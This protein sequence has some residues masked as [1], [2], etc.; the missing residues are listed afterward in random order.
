MPNLRFLAPL[1]LSTSCA[2]GQAT[3]APECPEPMKAEE[4][5]VSSEDTPPPAPSRS[6]VYRIPF[7]EGY[8]AEVIQGFHGGLS[9]SDELAYAV[10]FAC[11]VGEPIVA[12]RAGRV[13]SVKED[14]DKTCPDR[15]CANDGNYVVIDHGDGTYGSYNHLVH[16]GADVEVG[17]MVCA[18]QPIGRCGQTGWATRP[19]LHFS[20]DDLPRHSTSFAFLESAEQLGLDAA[21][22]GAKYAS[23]N[24][25]QTSCDEVAWSELPVDAFGHQ[26]VMLSEPIGLMRN[27]EPLVIRGRYHGQHPKVSIHRKPVGGGEWDRQCKELGDGSTFEFRLDWPEDRYP[28]GYYWLMITGATAACDKPGWDWSYELQ[29]SRSAARTVD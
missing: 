22:P 26:G 25:P 7:P 29:L 20:V 8:Q 2:T 13:W 1:L 21:I 4:Q 23:V 17:Q 11:N 12:S 3:V 19:H 5:E 9:H 10:D 24:A 18:G 16:M 14:S 15:S 6:P 28:D 27:S